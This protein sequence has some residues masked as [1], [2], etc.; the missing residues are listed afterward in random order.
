M[1]Q[2]LGTS[3]MQAIVLPVNIPAFCYENESIDVENIVSCPSTT[4]LSP[5][6]YCCA[7]CIGV[8]RTPAMLRSCSHIG[9]KECLFAHY[10]MN[11]KVDE[12]E[13]SQVV[14]AECPVC[15]MRY[16]RLQIIEFDYW[17][18]LAKYA[19]RSITVK[20]T[21]TQRYD[22]RPACDYTCSILDLQHHEMYECKLRSICCPNVGCDLRLSAAEISKHFPTCPKLARY[23]NIC[24]LPVYLVDREN[25][26]C[27]LAL[28]KVIRS[29]H[30]KNM[31][32]SNIVDEAETLG[33]AGQLSLK[34]ARATVAR[35]INDLVTPANSPVRVAS[36]APRRRLVNT[37]IVHV[38]GRRRR[39]IPFPEMP[40]DDEE[41]FG[42]GSDYMQL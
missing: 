5:T 29:L 12:T 16:D 35:T 11:Q 38:E 1:T 23:C 8:S 9:C 24:Q 40:E 6:M 39:A 17:T 37:P 2:Q 27:V 32:N 26:N 31:Y 30:D 20:C 34:L 19:Y 3:D 25:H 10:R 15:R 28:Q 33:T 4:E 7:V 22:Q 18:P 13:Y 36:L 42:R 14:Y 41:L 21:L